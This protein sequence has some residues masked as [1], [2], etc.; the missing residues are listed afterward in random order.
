LSISR[1][2]CGPD[3]PFA[4]RSQNTT[5]LASFKPTVDADLR[6]RW[7]MRSFIVPNRQSGDITLHIGQTGTPSRASASTISDTDLPVPVAPA[8]KP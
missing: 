4:A 6:T 8:I 5:G 2:W 7:L 3:G 1:Q